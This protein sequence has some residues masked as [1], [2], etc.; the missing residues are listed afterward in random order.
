MK[1]IALDHLDQAVPALGPIR[2]QRIAVQAAPHLNSEQSARLVGLLAGLIPRC[3][4]DTESLLATSSSYL[5][6]A[7]Q[8]KLRDLLT[9]S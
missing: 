6:A 8:A 2:M 1:R 5:N 9:A 3:G 7:A 4:V